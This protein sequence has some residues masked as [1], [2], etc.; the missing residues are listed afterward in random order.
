MDGD[1]PDT[2]GELKPSWWNST[3]LGGPSRDQ[4][5]AYPR[6]GLPFSSRP[7][8]PAR[9]RRRLHFLFSRRHHLSQVLPKREKHTHQRSKV[10]EEFGLA[11]KPAAQTR[12]TKSTATIRAL[13]YIVPRLENWTPLGTDLLY[14]PPYLLCR[15]AW[16][17]PVLRAREFPSIKTKVLPAP[18]EKKFPTLV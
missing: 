18:A 11:A 15:W 2:T 17:A 1:C 4:K 12:Q 13:P 7:P 6:K 5:R 16:P 10:P 8:C 9:D 14:I 3:G